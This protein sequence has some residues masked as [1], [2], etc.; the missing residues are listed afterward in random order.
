MDSGLDENKSELG[1][2]ILSVSVKVLSD[3][4]SLLDEVVKILRDLRG[5]A[6]LSAWVQTAQQSAKC[7]KLN[8]SEVL[9]PLSE[10]RRVDPRTCYGPLA[11]LSVP[12]STDVVKCARREG[13]SKWRLGFRVVGRGV[14]A[15]PQE[16]FSTPDNA[17]RFHPRRLS[18]RNTLMST[19]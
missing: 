18:L 1:V 12:D 17:S 7:H 19:R 14:H 16:H 15:K 9:V 5:K 2:G 6:S 4:D 13:W 8:Q 10:F 11:T 3:G